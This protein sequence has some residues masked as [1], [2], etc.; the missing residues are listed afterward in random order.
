M[1]R[2]SKGQRHHSVLAGHRYGRHAVR[3]GS[4]AAVSAGARSKK[5]RCG[6]HYGRTSKCSVPHHD[7]S[8]TTR[9][10]SR[11]RRP[12]HRAP[13]RGRS[14]R[15]H[16][17]RRRRASRK[18]QQP[19]GERPGVVHTAPNA[20]HAAPAGGPP[21]EATA[22]PAPAGAPV[23]TSTDATTN[24]TPPRRPLM[25]NSHTLRMSTTATKQS[26]TLRRQLPR[27]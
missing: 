8:P 9:R 26:R 22:S 12:H 3:Y 15:E 17:Q 1:R 14:D 18:Y 13:T 19:V 10:S 4:S 11:A 16:D 2:R 21:R 23:T 5:M 7:F 6:H 27:E 24:T 20:S 25:H